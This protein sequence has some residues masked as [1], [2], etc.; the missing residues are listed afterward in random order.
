MKNV[1]LEVLGSFQKKQEDRRKERDSRVL[2]LR[3][4]FPQYGKIQ[5][6]I[7]SC[8][9]KLLSF[10]GKKEPDIKQKI[11]D[12]KKR[13]TI[14]KD[15]K[16]AFFEDHRIPPDYDQ[17]WYDCPL[18]KD[19]GFLYDDNFIKEKCQCF[20]REEIRLKQKLSGLD[21]VLVK[22]NFDTFDFSLFNEEINPK[23][24]ISEREHMENMVLKAH[25]YIKNFDE[26]EDNL[27]FLGNPGLGKTFLSHAI[28]KELLFQNKMVVYVTSVD[29]INC[30]RKEQFSD[31]Y[32]RQ[33]DDFT[34]ED[35][36]NTDFLIIDD[37]GAESSTEYTAQQFF[38]IINKRILS[39]KKFLIS[40]N[41]SLEELKRKYG[42]R[43]L[44]RIQGT[45]RIFYFVGEDLR[46]KIRRKEAKRND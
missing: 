33:E 30:I 15:K 36:L 7:L 45:S 18:C 19:E 41:L 17:I 23:L 24:H 10:L 21:R 29:L 13:Y 32:E 46:L 40:T 27:F 4:K 20:V 14:L 28:A 42:E 3:Q 9:F 11:E 37:L 8:N 22:E 25:Q 39:G 43:V 35:F 31:Q 6:E 12:L 5:D 16:A 26:T 34:T 2:D 38:Y 44:S 1:Y